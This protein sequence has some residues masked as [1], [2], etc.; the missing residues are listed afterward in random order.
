MLFLAP[1]G[2]QANRKAKPWWM[3]F[4]AIEVIDPATRET[5]GNLSSL[6]RK[7]QETFTVLNDVCVCVSPKYLDPPK[8]IIKLSY[9]EQVAAFSVKIEA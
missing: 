9:T 3:Q 6:P 5:C 8:K 2:L 7:K 4:F 1:W